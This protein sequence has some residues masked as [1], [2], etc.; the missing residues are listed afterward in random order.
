MYRTQILLSP[1]TVIILLFQN[2]LMILIFQNTL[3]ILMFQI[4]ISRRVTFSTFFL[5]QKVPFNLLFPHLSFLIAT[6]QIHGS[7]LKM[8]FYSQDLDPALP[9]PP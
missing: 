8:N 6:E 1:H 7:F 2:T 5:S 4:L 9:F 3:M